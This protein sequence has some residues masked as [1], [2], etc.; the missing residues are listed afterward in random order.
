MLYVGNEHLTSFGTL[1]SLSLLKDQVLFLDVNYSKV[2]EKEDY[3]IKQMQ[4][5]VALSNGLV[6]RLNGLTCYLGSKTLPSRTIMSKLYNVLLSLNFRPDIV[7]TRSARTF[8][9]GLFLSKIFKVPLVLHVASIRGLKFPA[10]ITYNKQ[11]SELFRAPL[12]VIHHVFQSYIS[13]ATIFSER[14]SYETFKKMVYKPLFVVES[15]FAQYIEPISKELN[16]SIPIS[17]QYALSINSGRRGVDPTQLKILI[18]IAKHVKEVNFVIVGISAK[19]AFDIIQKPLPDNLIFVGRMSSSYLRPLY[20][21]ASVVVNPILLK[22]QSNRFLEA[23]FYRKA[24][25]TT[26]ECTFFYKN[27]KHEQHVIIE[28]DF[29][30]YPY[31][32]RKIINDH[33]LRHKLE[34]GAGEYLAKFLSPERHGRLFHFILEWVLQ[35]NV[36]SNF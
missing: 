3:L 6:V 25:I 31:W 32:V 26:S 24:I 30:N 36:N 2:K 14:F 15:V 1:A 18:Y 7:V 12:S 23:L 10:F 13:D 16:Y 28:D 35:N 22:A 19:D 27:L 29:T 5:N 21:N 8:Y 11:Y 4:L 34:T 17:K 9:V 20:I 33:E